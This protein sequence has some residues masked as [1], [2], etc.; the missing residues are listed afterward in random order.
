VQPEP[1]VDVVLVDPAPSP[2]SG[3]IVVGVVAVCHYAAD[4]KGVDELEG[5]Q[6]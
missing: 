1:L 6:I 3:V 2:G 5:C 4:R